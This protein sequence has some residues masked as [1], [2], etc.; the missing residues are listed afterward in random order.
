MI[1]Y[2]G[3]YRLWTPAMEPATRYPRQCWRPNRLL[4]WH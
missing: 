1:L 4:T 2:D 3:A